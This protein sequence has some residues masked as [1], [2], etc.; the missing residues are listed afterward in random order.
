[1]N[2][3]ERGLLIPSLDGLRCVAIIPVFLSHALMTVRL[4]NIIPGSFGVTLFFFLS[5]YLITTL[6]RLEIERTGTV[7]FRQF[8]VRRTLR[9]FPTCY[10]V[11]G[12]AALHGFYIGATD[13]WWLLGQALHLTNY[14]VIGGGWYAPIAPHT[15]IY[16]SLAVEEH[17]YL[18]FPVLF[19]VLARLPSRA[20][21]AG[22]LLAL[23]ALVFL[24]RCWLI[25]VMDAP[26][27][28][29]YVGTD[30]RID[31][32]LFG[33]VLALWG[34]PA[35]DSTRIAESTWKYVL[36][37]LAIVGILF[38]YAVPVRAFRETFGYSLQGM[39][40]F[41]VF[42]AAVRYPGWGPMRVL[43]LRWVRWIGSL[44]FSIYLIHP[45]ILELTEKLVGS[46]LPVLVPAATALTVVLAAALYYGVELPV[47]RMRKGLR[48]F[49]H[50]D[51]PQA[52]S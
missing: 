38:T 29:T 42:I 51:R 13:P 27:D 34:N 44:S 45:S 16:W 35:L 37:P 6:L 30:T 7:S 52:R 46:R 12:L 15:S 28:R 11:L 39:C 21:R 10:L 19:V 23:C 32:I 20:H 24:W 41:A 31:S 22:F 49:A 33:C 26:Y 3:A 25:F 36:L 9:I 47:R 14:Q 50:D 17:F 5:G 48:V 18:V 4:P 1:M 43:N 2:N 8:Y 40:L